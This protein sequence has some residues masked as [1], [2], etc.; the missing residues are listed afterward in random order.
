MDTLSIIVIIVGVMIIA[1]MFL[2]KK[3]S[4]NT[5]TEKFDTWAIRCA[6]LRS[7]GT[8]DIPAA[9][10]YAKNLPDSKPDTWAIRCALLRSFGTTNL[11]YIFENY[12]SEK[13]REKFKQQLQQR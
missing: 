13:N 1:N 8:T 6:L 12:M 5:S 7:F 4:I 11:D 3:K 9:L 2:A 10:E